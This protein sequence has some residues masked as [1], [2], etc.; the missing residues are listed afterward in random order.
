MNWIHQSWMINVYYGLG[1]VAAIIV[2]LLVG[3]KSIKRDLPF[4]WMLGIIGVIAVI[5]LGIG[6][7][8]G[9]CH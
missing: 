5:M 3:R 9:Y 2:G 8:I 6:A 4:G 1:M 7:Y